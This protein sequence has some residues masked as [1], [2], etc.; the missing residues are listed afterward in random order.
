MAR[1]LDQAPVVTVASRAE[2]RDWLAVNHA[3]GQ[4]TWLAT[5]RKHHPDHLANAALVEELLCWGWVDSLPRALDADRTMLM[6]A[7]RKVTS[8]WSAINKAHVARARA[9]GAMTPAGEAKIAAAQA[10]GMWDFLDDVERLEVPSDLAAALL[11]AG[12]RGAW[13]AFPRSVKRGTLEWLKM[14]KG[15][16]TRTARI[17]EIAESA[18]QGLRP[19]LFRR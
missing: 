12:G 8:A 9:S 16:E 1:A 18:G 13:D 4:T 15:S 3:G 14:A 2:L 11:T 19:K 7:P 10:N 17:S 6:I 5:Y